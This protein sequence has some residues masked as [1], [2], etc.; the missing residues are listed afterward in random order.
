[1]PNPTLNH[2]PL[3]WR[4][5]PE[6]ETLRTMSTK[7]IYESC[8]LMGDYRGCIVADFKSSNGG[9]RVHAESEVESN[10]RFIVT[11][12][13]THE[14]LTAEVERLKQELAELI[15]LLADALRSAK[16]GVLLNGV[17]F[18]K[19]NALLSLIESKEVTL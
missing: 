9:G 5:D 1:M 19:V 11:A 10:A 2:S 4:Y 18:G 14:S 3:P 6:S 8:T 13:N 15:E 16:Q 12:C 17:L 7:E